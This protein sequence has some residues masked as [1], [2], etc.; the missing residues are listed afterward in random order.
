M[1]W[2]HLGTYVAML[3][4]PPELYS[5]DGRWVE[6]L[7]D[8][9]DPK[10][11]SEVDVSAQVTPGSGYWLVTED[12]TDIAVSRLDV[13]LDG[14]RLRRWL[15]VPKGVLTP[16]RQMQKVRLAFARAGNER[17]PAPRFLGKRL[18]RASLV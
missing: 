3:D 5:L 1:V 10:P 6:V 4:D 12:I 14:C 11:Y 8:P 9:P 7:T 16:R 2:A 18:F 15:T 13:T 17:Q